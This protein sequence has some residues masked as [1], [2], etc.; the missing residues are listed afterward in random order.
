[1]IK[2]IS[3]KS[4]IIFLFL[5]GKI[6]DVLAPWKICVDFELETI[7]IKKRNWYLIGINENVHAFRFIRNIDIHQR[8]FGADIEI[9]SFGNSSKVFCIAKNEANEIKNVLIE[10]NQRR[11]GGFV[12]S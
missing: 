9:N 10:Y 1:M 6:E 7:I 11:K 3:S 5:N 4:S 12:I 8:I 2:E